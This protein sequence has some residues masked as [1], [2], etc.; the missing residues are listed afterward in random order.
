MRADPRGPLLRRRSAGRAAGQPVVGAGS[1]PRRLGAPA[2]EGRSRRWGNLPRGS[3]GIWPLLRPV[4]RRFDHE[5]SILH[6]LTPLLLPHTHK[7]GPGRTSRGS[8]PRRS[9]RPTSP[10]R[11]RE[12]TRADAEWLTA[13]DPSRIVVAPSGPSLCVARHVG[14]RP[15]AAPSQRRP[16]RLDPRTAQEPR[17]LLRLVP[18]LDRPAERRRTLVGRLDR[19]D[20]VEARPED[21]RTAPGQQPADPVPRGR[22]RRPALQALPDRRLLRLPLALRRVRLPRP[23]LAPAPHSRPGGP[24]QLDPRVRLARAVLLR[25]ADGPRSTTPMPGAEAEAIGRPIP[26]EPLDAA[27]SWANVARTILAACEATAATSIAA[28]AAA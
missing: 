24:K 9:R 8:A 1:G 18:H 16:G 14:R 26:Q 11:F 22:Q 10:W 6:D 28:S 3:V 12:S 27:Y 15:V 19:L 23:R 17:V 7:A 4:E 25:P 2:L 13:I 21:L 5:V 20:H